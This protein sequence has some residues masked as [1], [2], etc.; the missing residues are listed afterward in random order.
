M[1]GGLDDAIDDLS[2]MLQLFKDKTLYIQ[3]LLYSY[4]HQYYDQSNTD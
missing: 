1:R 2:L 4:V 3:K